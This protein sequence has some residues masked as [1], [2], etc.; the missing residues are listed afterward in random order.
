MRYLKWFYKLS[1]VFV[2][3]ASGI[4]FLLST[5]TGLYLTT[6]LATGMVPGELI[7]EGPEGRIISNFSVA[8]FNYKNKDLEIKLKNLVFKWHFPTLFK[9][10]LLVEHLQASELKIIL[11]NKENDDQKTDFNFPKLPLKITLEN[12]LIDKIKI[13][14]KAELETLIKPKAFTQL[15]HLKLQA[16]ISNQLWQIDSLNFNMAAMNFALK[17]TGQP[18]FPYSLSANLI[19]DFPNKFGQDIKGYANVNGNLMLY[20]WDGE[21]LN[22]ANIKINGSLKNG[23]D[24]HSLLS[25]QKMD[26][27]LTKDKSLQS[28]EGALLVE[29]KLPNLAIHLAT[30]TTAPFEANLTLDAQRTSQSLRGIAQIKIPQGELVFNLNYDEQKTPKI[31]GQLTANF[32]DLQPYSIPIQQL[33]YNS[34]FSGDSISLLTLNSEIEALYYG[35]LAR[36]FVNYKNQQAQGEF[37]LGNNKISF[38]GSP[39]YNWN[40]KAIIPEPKLLNP[41]LKNLETTLNFDAQVGNEND[42]HASLVIHP[43][44]Y[45]LEDNSTQKLKFSGGK[46]Q[47]LLDPK[48]LEIKGQ[49]KIDQ[50]KSLLLAFSLPKFDLDE[51]L[52]DSQK[53]EGNLNLKVS[54]LDFLE[55]FSPEISEIK[56][57]LS[58][59]LKV[60]GTIS[61]P[62]VEGNLRLDKGRLLMSK[63]G[64]DL[65]PVLVHLQSHDKNWKVKGDVNSQGQTLIIDGQGTFAPKYTGTINIEAIDFPLIKTEEYQVNISPQL[66][67]IIS[68]EGLA[69]NGKILVPNAQI[70]PQTFTDSISLSSDA[71]LVSAKP[72]KPTN[73]LPIKTDISIEMGSNVA[74]NVKGMQ[75]LL[76]GKIHLRQLPDGPLNASGQLNVRDGKYK[77]YG[78]DLKIEQGE[79]LFTGGLIDNPGINIRASRSFSNTNTSAA[80]KSQSLDFN[81]ANQQTLN[82]GENTVVGV[83]VTGRIKSPRV[84][85]FSEPSTLSQADILSMLILGKPVNQAN[86]AGGQLL[87]KAITSMN[88]GSNS[89]GIQLL[90]QLKQSLGFDIDFKTESKLDPETNKISDSNSVVVGKS[91]SKKVYISYN[92]GLSKNDSNVVT[93]TYLL[94]K[95]FSIQVNT[96]TDVSSIDLLYTHKKD[97]SR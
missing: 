93:L 50:N 46:I 16:K 66:V 3:V 1:L 39:P 40:I 17:A 27:P 45:L 73:P 71:V 76:V 15:N 85:L 24:M 33:K 64:L 90:E 88:L 36:G 72:S 28:K 84:E 25:W 12:L 54:S 52:K 9:R 56:G 96:N 91:L 5:N 74:L 47:A 21:L 51:G 31:E 30:N 60:S 83:L 53:I 44:T 97:N 77:A 89:R 67:L 14:Q 22:P 8:K 94:N 75:G 62:S 43:G 42:G 38:K 10:H 35:K 23:S 70:K 80:S 49:V 78:Q 20:Q 57:E 11:I 29:G 26:W 69:L 79:I 87:L 32:L 41:Q 6:K 59:L 55:Q 37:S 95:F 92:F 34:E 7:I 58:A 4:V 2:L 18:V 65:N 48:N 68:P 19:Y 86:K 61:K 81:S 13:A 82:F 63:L